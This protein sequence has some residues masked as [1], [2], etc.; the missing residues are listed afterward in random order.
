MSL[1][2]HVK[3][4]INVILIWV[5]FLGA[6]WL[7]WALYTTFVKPEKNSHTGSSETRDTH[8]DLYRRERNDRTNW[9]PGSVGQ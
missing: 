1:R 7:C 4:F 6:V 8:D 3:E 9:V 2:D 5:V